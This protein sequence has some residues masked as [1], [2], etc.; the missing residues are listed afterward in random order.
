M[1]VF[2]DKKGKFRVLLEKIVLLLLL[3]LGHHRMWG[4][5]QSLDRVPTH[6]TL[7][8]FQ[9]LVRI[10]SKGFGGEAGGDTRSSC[11]V[12]SCLVRVAHRH[13]GWPARCLNR[14]TS[15]WVL[16]RPSRLVEPA[17]LSQ[18]ERERSGL[19][20]C[21]YRGPIEQMFTKEMQPL[22]DVRATPNQVLFC[23]LSGQA[24]SLYGG[25]FHFYL[26]WCISF[27]DLLKLCL[28]EVE[29][30]ISAHLYFMSE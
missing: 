21:N 8:C 7:A 10:V 23:S 25:I 17:N 1:K 4:L 5:A 26:C 29:K 12:L 3:L 20:F 9:D 15:I 11:L 19:I 27:V 28:F 24:I 14:A 2:D 22:Q 18:H 6:A 16:V 30:N 13:L